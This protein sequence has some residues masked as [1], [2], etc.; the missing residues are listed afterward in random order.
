MATWVS[1]AC[2]ACRHK[3]AAPQ[4][5]INESDLP[6]PSKNIDLAILYRSVH[7]LPRF[8]RKSINTKDLR[9]RIATWV[10]RACPACRHKRAA[11]T[12]KIKES[13]P[14]SLSLFVDLALLNRLVRSLPRNSLPDHPPNP[15]RTSRQTNKQEQTRSR[16]TAP[17]R[18]RRRTPRAHKHAR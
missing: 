2:P 8:S 13:D 18:P 11:P 6:S 15:V 10:R 3:R 17:A 1:R 7:F 9:G 16:G 14:T 12:P 4:P 5:K